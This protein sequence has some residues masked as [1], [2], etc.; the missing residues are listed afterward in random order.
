MFKRPEIIEF[1]DNSGKEIVHR[2]PENGSG[3]F[4]LGSQCVVRESQEAVFYRD[5]K[6]MDV[7]GPGRHTLTTQNIPLLAGLVDMAFSGEGTPFRAEVYY[8]NKKTFTDMKWGT[9]EPIPFRDKELAMVRL[10]AFGNFSMKV[11]DSQLFVNKLVGTEGRYSTGDIEGFLKNMI[12]SRLTDLLGETIETVF[13]LPAYYDEI[14]TLAKSRFADDFGKYGIQLVDFYISAIT[15]PE[16]V[17][18]R[19]DERSSMAAVGD[20]DAYMRFK[21]ATAMGDAATAGGGGAAGAGV[22]M[23]AG[24]G[25]GMAMANQMGAAMNRN[26]GG[27][28]GGGAAAAATVACPSC[29]KSV[30]E[31][32][33]CPECGKP[34][35]EACASCGKPMPAGSKFCPS[36]GARAG[37]GTKCECGA[38]V[39]A[40]S[41]FCPDCGKKVD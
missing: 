33:F 30:P 39:P 28:G 40:G 16:E 21:T 10:R 2:V 5:G 13:D 24:L 29:G 22:G 38:D 6:A 17:Q 1:L 20:I 4:R 9:K 25:M 31:G 37:A 15:P 27:G 34:M 35:A 26:T 23:G 7:L 8:V 41:K 18:K 36:C 3:E 19:I 14:G 12:I 11:S 32:K